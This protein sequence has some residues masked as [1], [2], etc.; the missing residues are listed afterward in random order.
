[1]VRLRRFLA[2]ARPTLMAAFALV[3]L[4]YLSRFTFVIAQI[5]FSIETQKGFQSIW[6]VF[7]G[8]ALVSFVIAAVPLRLLLLARDALIRAE[9]AR[10]WIGV[11]VWLALLAAIA[12][13][14]GPPGLRASGSTVAIWFALY[15]AC[16]VVAAARRWVVRRARYLE[17]AR[18]E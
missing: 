1:M 6:P 10:F 17:A 16:L 18:E 12:Y 7:F 13:F 9:T 5:A 8:I 15:G 11:L 3:S 4:G 2:W 14:V